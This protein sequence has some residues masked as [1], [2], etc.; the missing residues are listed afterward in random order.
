MTERF[1][2]DRWMTDRQI[3]GERAANVKANWKMFTAG[4]F[5]RRVYGYTLCATFCNF[6]LRCL[7]K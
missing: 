2:D 6:E 7:N 3:D 4:E 1:I 5:G